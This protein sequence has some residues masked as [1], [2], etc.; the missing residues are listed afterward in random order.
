MGL[1]YRTLICGT[2]WRAVFIKN[3]SHVLDAFSRRPLVAEMDQLA[4]HSFFFLW[5]IR[6]SH[7]SSIPPMLTTHI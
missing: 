1:S 4:L 3:N 2:E 6:F 7:I 5:V